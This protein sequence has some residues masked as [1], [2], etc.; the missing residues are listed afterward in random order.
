[1]MVPGG[2]YSQGCHGYLL[3]SLAAPFS[4]TRR[5]PH[6]HLLLMGLTKV[7]Y[8]IITGLCAYKD[9]LFIFSGKLARG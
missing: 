9:G 5:L 4:F 2:C 8:H 7:N 3:G 6:T 1:M